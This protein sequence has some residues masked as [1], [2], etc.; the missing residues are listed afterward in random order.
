MDGTDA[1]MLSGE[2]AVGKH[3]AKVVAAMAD[4]C[5]EAE[6]ATVSRNSKHRLGEQFDRIDEGIAMSAMYAANH[7]GVKGIGAPD[8]IWLYSIVDV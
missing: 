8:R 6:Q 3:P 5:E 7:M 4:I 1:V 2:T